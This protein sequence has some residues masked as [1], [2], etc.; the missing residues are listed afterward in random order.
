MNLLYI[1]GSTLILIGT[2]MFIVI[3]IKEKKNEIILTKRKAKNYAIIIPAKGES[4]VIEN[5]LKSIKIQNED[6]SNVYVVVEDSEDKTCSIVKRYKANV[7]VRT[8]PLRPRKG[9]ALDECLKEIIKTKH[10]D[11]YFIFDAD[12]ILHKNYIKEMIKSYNKGYDIATGYRNISNPLNVVSVC[13]E[14]VFCMINTLFNEQKIKNNKTIILSGTGFFI[15]GYLIEK[16]NGFPFNTLTEDYEL[17]LCASI[18]N[19][20]TTYNKKA[21]FYD[22]QPLKMSISIKQRTRWV[23]GFL[24][25]RTKRLKNTKVHISKRLGITPYLFVI[26]G[27]VLIILTDFIEIFN[28]ILL[29]LNYGVVILSLVRALLFLYA[30]LLL[31]TFIVLFKEEEKLNI[32]QKMKIKGLFFNPIF[33][34]SFV[35]CFLL[36]I[37]KKDVQ[38]TKIEH[39]GINV[40]EK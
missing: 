17:S 1:I 39:S 18:D 16:W 32:N 13:S 20:S 4:K 29:N 5:I 26:I 6:M 36:S 37:F 27:V 34:A 8:K 3:I 22:E 21:M 23:K 9:Y 25:S 38:W 11:L 28:H 10:Y 15:A 2:I 30:L 7:H 40:I 33:L 12:N 19:I 24:D 35:W 14:L 31:F